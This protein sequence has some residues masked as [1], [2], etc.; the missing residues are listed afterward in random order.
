M[1][2]KNSGKLIAFLALLIAATVVLSGCS[3]PGFTCE[4]RSRQQ[5]E[6]CNTDCGEG[7]GAEL[8]KT[9]CTGEHAERLEQCKEQSY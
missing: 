5:L 7:I 2:E 6:R 3:V 4:D 8:C 9:A 1:T